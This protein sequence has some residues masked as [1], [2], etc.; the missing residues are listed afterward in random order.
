MKLDQIPILDVVRALG[1]PEPK[2]KRIPAWWRN[3]DGL[4][5]SINRDKNSFYDFAAGAGGG[6]LSLVMMVQGCDK[7]TAL[8]WLEENAGLDKASG[9]AAV[10]KNDWRAARLWAVAVEIMADTVL[11]SMETEDPARTAITEIRRIA[12]AGGRELMAEY[13]TWKQKDTRFTA[14]LVH[15]GREHRKRIARRLALHLGE[16]SNAA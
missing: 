11:E 5:V 10:P 3:G 14:G 12:R 9:K 4:N 15:I 2:G 16:I 7:K 8:R 13:R 1:G 6:V